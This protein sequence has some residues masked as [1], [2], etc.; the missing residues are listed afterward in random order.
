MHDDLKPFSQSPSQ[1]FHKNSIDFE[2]PQSLSK[3]P[4]VRLEDMKCMR[5]RDKSTYQMK[6]RRSLGQKTLGKKFEVR[7]RGFG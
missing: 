4:K 6:K 7:E 2:N 5:K 1:K 3:I